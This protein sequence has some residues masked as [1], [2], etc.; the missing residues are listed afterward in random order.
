MARGI[1]SFTA[2]YLIRCSQA[3]QAITRAVED[4]E[5]LL[6]LLPE[7]AD[8]RVWARR[9][10]ALGKAHASVLDAERY[11]TICTQNDSSEGK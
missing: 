11:V 1:E 9:R 6:P 8:R 10:E 3:R 2:S 4:I 7:G 5:E